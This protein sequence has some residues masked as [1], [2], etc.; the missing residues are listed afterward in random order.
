MKKVFVLFSLVIGLSVKAQITVRGVFRW[1]MKVETIELWY[2]ICERSIGEVIVNYM[3]RPE[4]TDEI[5][6][7]KYHLNGEILAIDWES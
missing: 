1:E 2:T 6:A 5:L 3:I 7:V 4:E